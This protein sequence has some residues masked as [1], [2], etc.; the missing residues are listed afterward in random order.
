M[1]EDIKS[2]YK[3]L[4]HLKNKDSLDEYGIVNLIQEEEMF[5]GYEEEDFWFSPYPLTGFLR[6]YRVPTYIHMEQIIN[7]KK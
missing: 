4:I 7:E 1:G 3:A 6:K 2:V 5:Y